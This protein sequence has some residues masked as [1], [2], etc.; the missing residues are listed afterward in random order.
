MGNIII[1]YL[2]KFNEFSISSR[3][4]IQSKYSNKKGIYLWVNN[5]NNKSYVGKSMNLYQRILFY[6]KPGYIHKTH[7]NCLFVLLLL[8]MVLKILRCIY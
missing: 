6:L 5:I 2:D 4:K 8:Y 1:H 7:K 3:I